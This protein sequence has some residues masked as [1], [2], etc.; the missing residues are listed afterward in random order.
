MVIVEYCRFGSLQDFL[1]KHRDFFVNQIN[2]END[3][4]DATI[5]KSVCFHSMDPS[6][7]NQPLAVVDSGYSETSF[8][9]SNSDENRFI[10][11]SDLVCWLFQMARGMKYLASRKVL[12]GDLAA[13]NVLLTDG[14]VVKI[15]DF[16]LARSLY[17]QDHYKKENDVSARAGMYSIFF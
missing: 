11:T 13:R 4:I 14:N 17:K 6:E 12:H 10:T 8:T 5:S 7:P 1:I 15:C 3:S 16:G 9:A 2:S